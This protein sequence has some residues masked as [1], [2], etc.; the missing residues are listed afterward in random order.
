MRDRFR[1][2]ALFTVGMVL[3]LMWGG[4]PASAGGGGGCH[5]GITT[6]EGDADGATVE[7]LDACFTPTTLQ[8]DPGVKVT[9]VSRD[10]GLTHNVGGNQWGYF[11]DLHEGDAFSA[12]FDEPGTYPYACS[13]HPG[14]TGAIIV[15]S[16]MGEGNGAVVSVQPFEAPEPLV[17]TR[18]VAAERPVGGWIAVG[19]IGLLFGAAGGIGLMKLRR[20][21][22]A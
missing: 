12:T 18:S 21:A 1:I 22:A 16:G 11:D 19:A 8:V 3:L 5:Q 20:T 17:V 14:M 10:V 9:F 2:L 4:A 15:G 6:G 7:M 13:Y